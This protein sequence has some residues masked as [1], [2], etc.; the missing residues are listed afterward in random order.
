M[1]REVVRA[2]HH[3]LLD[4]TPVF[5]RHGHMMHSLPVLTISTCVMVPRAWA[6]GREVKTRIFGQVKNKIAA[7]GSS[8]TSAPALRRTPSLNLCP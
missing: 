7:Q 5:A 6:R 2:T 8:A 4:L 3:A 1:M